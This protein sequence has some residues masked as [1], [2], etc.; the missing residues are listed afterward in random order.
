MKRPQKPPRFDLSDIAQVA[1]SAAIMPQVIAHRGPYLHWDELRSRPLPTNT[2]N[3]TDWWLATKFLRL[4]G[5]TYVPLRSTEGLNCHFVNCEAVQAAVHQIDM[6][7]GGHVNLPT[8]VNPASKD[9]Y[10]VRSLVEEAIHSSQLEGATTTRLVAKRM[11]REG[12]KPNDRSEQMIVNNYRT[13]TQIAEWRDQP[14]TAELV[15]EVHRRITEHTLDGDDISGRLRTTDERIE[16]G[17][18]YGEVFHVPP[19]ADELPERLEAMCRF[20]NGDTPDVF[21]HPL[22]R[23]IILHYWLAYDHPFVDGNGRTARALFYWSMLRSGY[24]IFEFISISAG[25]TRAPAKYGRAFLFTQT[26]DHDL[27][28]FLLHQL[29]IVR[30]AVRALHDY[31]LQTEA[32]AREAQ[33]LLEGFELN[34]RQKA[35]AAHALRHPG[36]QYTIEG[37][38]NSHG[39]VYQTART[40]LLEMEAKGLLRSSKA[41]RKKLIFEGTEL[42]SGK[43]RA[44][45]STSFF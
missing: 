30:D 28:Y 22:I 11:L 35:L 40:D 8:G 19:P 2:I 43:D 9:R 24:W 4:A 20:A 27:T 36:H 45:A 41:R 33:S 25:L 21:L 12:R 3:H 15:F 16:V 13:M 10:L 1:R 34:H 7:A 6:S 23:A 32:H 5:K 26:D 17:D 31:L 39:V 37:H 14:L 38:Q 18:D 29:G 44:K 42:L